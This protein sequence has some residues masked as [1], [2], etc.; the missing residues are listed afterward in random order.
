MTADPVQ[1]AEIRAWIATE[2]NRSRPRGM[3]PL[4]GVLYQPL[5]FDG[6]R[7]L[8]CERD[9]CEARWQMLRTAVDYSQKR[10]LDLGDGHQPDAAPGP[11][12][13]H[14]PQGPQERRHRGAPAHRRA[15]R[16]GGLEERGPRTVA[17]GPRASRAEP[18]RP[19]PRLSPLV[20]LARAA[21]EAAHGLL[22]LQDL[23]LHPITAVEA[24]RDAPALRRGLLDRLLALTEQGIVHNEVKPLPVQRAADGQVALIDLETARFQDEPTAAW[25][26]EVLEPNP[27]LGVGAY[28]RA[29]HAD[30]RGHLADLLG[31]D[32]TLSAWGLPPLTPPER[33]RCLHVL[34]PDRFAG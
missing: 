22:R 31:A 23:G 4:D 12:P 1:A 27:V 8:A 28:P 19:G 6:L 11:D 32:T 21:S 2:F 20:D 15:R 29:I 10:L 33:L 26:A 7:D 13:V 14:P 5:P 18:P 3:T 9:S 17:R 25:R 34:R 16:R 24:A 30:G